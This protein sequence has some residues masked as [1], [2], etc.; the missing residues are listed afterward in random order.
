VDEVVRV[1]ELT[2]ALRASPAPDGTRLLYTVWYSE[3]GAPDSVRPTP[4]I[5]A[6]T[7]PW[8]SAVAAEIAQF[9]RPLR[10]DSTPGW[11]DLVVTTGAWSEV[12]IAR[13]PTP[14]T[15]LN[16]FE[17]QYRARAFMEH[18][19][20]AAL[21][22]VP[23]EVMV[24]V[25]IGDDGRV[26]DPRV[27]ERSRIPGLDEEAVRLSREYRFQPVRYEGLPLEVRAILPI[28]FIER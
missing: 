16:D 14:P 21:L 2:E 5:S 9:L 11:L 25:V 23:V 27:L 26:Q 13:P 7:V 4:G 3:S 22:R 20:H 1:A 17:I 10:G 18:F 24:R 6:D 12:R 19:A 28:L 15:S 8:A